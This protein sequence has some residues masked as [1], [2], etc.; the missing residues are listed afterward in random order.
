MSSMQI[1]GAIPVQQMPTVDQFDQK[2][3]QAAEA[4]EKQFLDVMLKAMRKTVQHSEFSEPN[5][6]EKI[7]REQLDN[8][9][10]K[11]WSENGGLGLSQLIYE[12]VKAQIS[13][14]PVNKTLGALPLDQ[15][16]A[17]PIEAENES[18]ALSLPSGPE[19]VDGSREAQ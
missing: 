15:Q 4:Y 8:E 18:K 5:H 7:F 12:Q 16:K 13:P 2:L 14:P 19:S 11:S 17:L 1:P 10:T 3:R 9:Y 6:A